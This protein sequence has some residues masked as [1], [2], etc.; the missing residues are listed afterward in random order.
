MF[1]SR[2]APLYKV[3]AASRSRSSPMVPLELLARI[4]AAATVFALIALW[5]VLA[6]RRAWSVGRRERWPHNIGILVIDA[7]AVRILIPTAAVGAA[8]FAAGNGWGLFHVAGLRLSVASLLGFLALD[9]VIYA[10]HVAF[11]KVPLLWRLHR[12]HHADLDIDVT[13]GV[14]F[15][16]F[17]ILI[18]MLIKIAV[19]V[20]IGVPA[21]A[22]IAFE[23]VLNATSMFNHSNAT[24]PLWLDR[25]VRFLVVTPDMHRVHHS[26]LAS[27]TDSNF[28]FNLPWWDRMFGTYRAEPQAG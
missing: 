19:V 17:E 24:M 14:R 9:L 26:V 8:L 6:P 18:S 11:H 4:A 10:Q 25:I 28:G 16:P 2:P 1:A 20:L 7:L 5:E 12:M 3:R 21:L 23:V 15:H 22:V 27:E 13:T